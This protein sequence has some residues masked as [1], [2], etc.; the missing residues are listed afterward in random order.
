MHS[1]TAPIDPEARAAA[2]ARHPSARLRPA[3]AS[4]PQAAS[5]TALVALLTGPWRAQDPDG[6]AAA[7]TGAPMV[8]GHPV[9]DLGWAAAGTAD[10]WSAG[11]LEE[12]R[13]NLAGAASRIQPLWVA[14]ELSDGH[15]GRHVY[16][17]ARGEAPAGGDGP[18]LF[19]VAHIVERLGPRG[20]RSRSRSDHSW[21]VAVV[22]DRAGRVTAVLRAVLACPDGCC[23]PLP[24][25]ARLPLAAL[26]ERLVG[27]ALAARPSAPDDDVEA[28]VIPFPSGSDRMPGPPGDAV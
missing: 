22:G 14:D 4:L 23:P 17:E 7:M 16:V 27:P 24:A 13:H 20:E 25:W 10:P 19:V 8:G 11:V 6:F 1:S 18:A 3:P 28:T 9:L 15:G 21:M 2:I 26:R 5:F 12:L